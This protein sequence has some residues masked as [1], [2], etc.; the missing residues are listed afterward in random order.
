MGETLLQEVYWAAI[1]TRRMDF[2]KKLFGSTTGAADNP[3][4]ALH[5]K[6]IVQSFQELLDTTAGYAYEKQWINTDTIG[7]RPWQFDTASGC[8]IFVRKT[9][10]SDSTA[11][12]FHPARNN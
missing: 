12:W 4:F 2:L 8:I 11:T 10:S 7:N 3:P 5:E 6:L 1:N 9:A